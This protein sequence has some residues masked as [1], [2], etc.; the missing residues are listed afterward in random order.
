MYKIPFLVSFLLLFSPLHAMDTL[1]ESCPLMFKEST[2][3][4]D[5]VYANNAKRLLE[6]LTHE[7]TLLQDQYAN[8]MVSKQ[9]EHR[10]NVERILAGAIKHA[11]VFNQA[12]RE[13]HKKELEVRARYISQL[14]HYTQQTIPYYE[15]QASQS[16]ERQQSICKRFFSGGV[17]LVSTFFGDCLALIDTRENSGDTWRKENQAVIALLKEFKE[18]YSEEIMRLE[19]PRIIPEDEK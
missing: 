8:A 16:K 3:T 13:F 18:M 9:Q 14:K 6:A 2:A 7:Q 12:D 11:S 15:V 10:A 5:A 4:L 19:R 17:C 1:S